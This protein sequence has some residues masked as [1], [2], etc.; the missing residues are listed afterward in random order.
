MLVLLACYAIAAIGAPALVR[1]W[2]PK[3][4]YAVAAV[5]AATFVWA[6]TR[7]GAMRSGG[8][9]AETHPWVPELGL[10]ISLRMSTFPWVMVLLV[11]GVGALVLAYSAHY[12]SSG[13]AGLGRFAAV[14]TAFAGAMFGLVVADDLLL[15]Y[16]FWELTSVFS[17]LLIGHDPARSASRWAAMQALLVTTLG[18]LAMLTGFIM[19]GQH[20]GTYRL[21]EVVGH[22]PGGAYL[23]IALVLVLLGA[24]SKSAVFP[25]SFWLPSAMAAPTPVSAYLHAA[26]MVKAGVFLI[27]MLTP[28]LASE[29]PWQ[30]VIWTCG[31]VTFLFGG[32]TALRQTDLKLMLAYGTVSQLGM[33]SIVLGTGTRTAA[34]AGAALLAGHAMFKAAL[35]LVVG[36]VDKTTGT[37]EIY[38]L[39][40]LGARRPLLAAV[41]AVAVAS[42][43]GFPPTLGFVAK[44]AMLAAFWDGG[45]WGRAM[46]ACLIAG[47]ALTVAY[48]LRFLWG[49]FARKAD[50]Q[51]TDAAPIG[52]GFIAAPVLLALAGLGAGLFAPGV[53]ELLAPYADGFP[54]AGHAYHLALWHGL[55]PALGFSALALATG[56]GLFLALHRTSAWRSLKLP[57]KSG[58]VYKQAIGGV[59]RVAVELTGRTQRG[60]LPFYLGVILV[61]LVVFAGGL[62]VFDGPWPVGIELFDTPLQV[63]AG[64]IIVIAAIS[65]AVAKRRLTAM[66]LTGVSG[67]GVATLFIFHGA[68]DLALTQF[69]VETVTIVMFVLVLRR[70][71]ARFSERPLK[72]V[73]RFRVAVGIAVGVVASGM[74]YV[75]VSGRQ[76][77]PISEL[78]PDLA[79]SYGGGHNIVNVILVDIRAWDTMGE[80]AVLLVAATGVASLIFGRDRLMHRRGGSRPA[81]P[82]T[83]E[84]VKWLYRPETDGSHQAIILQVVTRL[85]FHTI[86]LFSIY[87]LFTGHNHPGG[88]FAGG[89]VAGLALAIRYLAGGRAELNAAAPVDAGRLLGTGL[90]ISVGTGAA[91]MLLGGEVLQSAIL[92]FD[93][94]LVG[95]VHFVTS[96]FFD[97][98]VYLI[99]VGLVL[100][101]L[102][103]LGAEIDR[104]QESGE[105]TETLPQ[106][107][108]EAA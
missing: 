30:Q 102:R 52:P 26:A 14:F 47:A 56:F 76:A 70:L 91:S 64:G 39:S 12:F 73:R 40:G 69:L 11:S 59:D 43:I 60:S 80:I 8:A 83:G 78:F 100:D 44:E 106:L 101:I 3:A 94:P 9:V 68:P 23:V 74:A 58:T 77:A 66:V 96:T 97:I 49:A 72:K 55:T 4:M 17:Y 42:M 48:G 37:R 62:L 5:P 71:P 88:G 34:L 22:L 98:G 99:V 107:E 89:L 84:H 67:Y 79:V 90:L 45:P 86:V 10:E 2:G 82:R 93:L 41:A 63:A 36:I 57:F 46:L 54:E 20:A 28:A 27:G 32:W 15:L 81:P 104:H 29:A 24:L 87:L 21:S 105:D 53:D 16:V 85:L 19:L 31:A 35:F 103:S 6:L 51:E 13:E 92:D 25:F 95:H 7:T 38:T 1:W 65:A 61:T 50:A 33:I 18:G 75:A 108:K